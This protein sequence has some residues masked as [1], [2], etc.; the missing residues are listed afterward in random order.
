MLR[1]ASYNIRKCVG[2]DGRRRPRRI[3]EVIRE[4]DA[5]ILALQE[6]DQRLGPRVAALPRELLLQHTGYEVVPVAT[7]HRRLGWHGNALLVKRPIEVLSAARLHIPRLEPR[8]AVMAELAVG[9][10]RLRVVAAHLSL[11]RRLR[12]RQI[13]A[14]GAYLT[15]LG[16]AVPTILLGDFNE[17]RPAAQVLE[18]LPADFEV[19][20]PGRSFPAALPRLGLDHIVTGPGLRVRAAGVHRSKRARIASDHLPVWAEIEF[21]E[22][23]TPSLPGTG[24]TAARAAG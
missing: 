15:R 11:L 20:T 3:I 19:Q 16:P 18:L 13:V 14:V 4:L 8:G 9:G 24:G 12:R 6:A 21:A 7:S 22:A 17:W 2:L 5:D 10:R 1:V 23:D